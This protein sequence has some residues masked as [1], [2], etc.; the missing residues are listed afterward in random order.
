MCRTEKTTTG[1]F[2]LDL[3]NFFK[4]KYQ[5]IPK[6][7][8][9]KWEIWSLFSDVITKPNLFANKNAV[10]LAFWIYWQKIINLLQYMLFDQREQGMSTNV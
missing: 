8:E 9:K 5:A 7:S 3:F 2:L 4:K 1:I 6:H 10:S